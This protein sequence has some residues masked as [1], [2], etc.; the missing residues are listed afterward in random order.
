MG[1][2]SERG[3]FDLQIWDALGHQALGSDG[4]NQVT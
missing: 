2:V 1:H 3:A 4:V